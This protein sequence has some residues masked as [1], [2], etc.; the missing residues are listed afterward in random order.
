MADVY[1]HCRSGSPRG[2]VG[3][4]LDW[5]KR[6]KE[7]LK[8]ARG[9][10]KKPFYRAIRKY[11]TEVWIHVVLVHGVTPKEAKEFEK[12]WIVEL[13]MRPPNG[14]NLTDG[15][16]GAVGCPPSKKNRRATSERMYHR[17]H[18]PIMRDEML[19]T[20]RIAATKSAKTRTG[21]KL[22]GKHLKRAR[23]NVA[24]AHEVLRRLWANDSAYR[25]KMLEAQIRG[26]KN[27]HKRQSC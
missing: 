1:L 18:D 26:G 16:D 7:H 22:T 20:V 2:Y 5:R 19:A 8:I 27:R 9:G 12:F 10:D 21:K 25:A 11:G 15:G 6:W 3:W 24:K 4:A 17:W 13:N 23:A 14:Y